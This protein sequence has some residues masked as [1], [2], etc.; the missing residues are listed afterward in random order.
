MKKFYLL[1]AALLSTAAFAQSDFGI[2]RTVTIPEDLVP[3][4]G[5]ETTNEDGTVSYGT[6]KASGSAVTLSEIKYS[7]SGGVQVEFV[8]GSDARLNP[9]KEATE[10]TA[11]TAEGEATD[12]RYYLHSNFNGAKVADNT[13]FASKANTEDNA[14]AKD[15]NMWVGVQYTVPAGITLSVD[16]FSFL[17]AYGNSFQ[18]QFELVD[19]EG[20]ILW[21]TKAGEPFKVQSYNQAFIYG[22]SCHITAEHVTGFHPYSAGQLGSWS[23]TEESYYEGK[24][25]DDLATT[26]L[27]ADLKLT[28]GT[29][30]LKVYYWKDGPKQWTPC[31]IALEGKAEAAAA[32]SKIYKVTNGGLES[33]SIITD[34]DGVTMTFGNECGEV[35]FADVEQEIAGETFTC[36]AQGSVNPSPNKGAVPEAGSFLMFEV[37]TPGT[38]T[39]YAEVGGGKRLDVVAN[40]TSVGFNWNGEAVEAGTTK[41]DKTESAISFPVEADGVYYVYCS[42]SKIGFYGFGF[43]AGGAGIETVAAEQAAAQSY[44]IMGQKV[45]TVK[46]FGIQNGKLIYVK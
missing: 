43:T 41:D 40:G 46:G 28:E 33:G 16:A 37:A 14:N 8:K 32:D 25:A 17:G 18:H 34:V 4:A 19:G 36:R 31:K 38:L 1:S 23:I 6:S 44:N 21:Q 39:V 9:A 27:P 26:L 10:T 45:S 30:T 13:T 2:Y 5:T 11:A 22:D 3:C 7:T 24:L 35:K 42:G 12:L 15:E 20:N 29:Y